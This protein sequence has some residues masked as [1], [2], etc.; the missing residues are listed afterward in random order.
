MHCRVD[1]RVRFVVRGVVRQAG[2]GGI[3]HPTEDD[4]LLGEAA[5]AKKHVRVC[6]QARPRRQ[7]RRHRIPRWRPLL[8]RLRGKQEP[9][10]RP[11]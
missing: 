2:T 9:L 8:A 11:R 5:I 1:G 7:P 6:L 4:C 10:L 3:L